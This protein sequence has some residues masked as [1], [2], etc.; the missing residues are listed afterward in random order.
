MAK[1]KGLD[2]EVERRLDEYLSGKVKRE[3]RSDLK[4][5]SVSHI[6]KEES[7]PLR[8]ACEMAS[9]FDENAED[10]DTYRLKEGWDIFYIIRSLVVL[11]RRFSSQRDYIKELESRL[12]NQ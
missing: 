10:D 6:G 5:E 8:T 4:K 9:W 7:E 1:T 3:P 11:W 12:K 2:P